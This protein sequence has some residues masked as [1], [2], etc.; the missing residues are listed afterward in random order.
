VPTEGRRLLVERRPSLVSIVYDLDGAGHAG[1]DKAYWALAEA[2]VSAEI[3]QLPESVGHKGGVADLYRHL[4]Y[5]D[6]ALRHALATLPRR[7]P[8]P[9][10]HGRLAVSSAAG[11]ADGLFARVKERVAIVD[12]ASHLTAL[13]ERAAGRYFVGLCPFH[14]ERRPSFVVWPEAGAFKCLSCGA[15]G[16]VIRLAQLAGKTSAVEA[17]RR[18]AA[19]HG[20]P[21]DAPWRGEGPRRRV[22]SIIIVGRERHAALRV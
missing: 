1:A 21:V 2:G 9:R 6:A 13:E 19:K 8:G 7:Q 10:P 18:L 15:A 17:A 22:G 11:S 20:V 5:D 3:V 12:V 16:D 4:A 14:N